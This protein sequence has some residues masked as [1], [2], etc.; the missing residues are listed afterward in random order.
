MILSKYISATFENNF[1][2]VCRN[3]IANRIGTVD[4]ISLFQVHVDSQFFL[5]N[6]TK[7]FQNDKNRTELFDFLI[8]ILIL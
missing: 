6:R 4:L 1:N 7:L 2:R 5:S 8:K 3:K